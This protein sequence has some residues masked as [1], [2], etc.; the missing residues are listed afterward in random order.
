MGLIWN[1]RDETVDWV[2]ALSR[3]MAPYEDGTPR[4]HEGQWR[5]VFPAEGFGELR[6]ATFEHAH[7]GDFESVVVDR[8]LSVS[9]IAALPLSQRQEVDRRIRQLTNV[10]PDLSDQTE[11][12][13]P[14]RTLV[15]WA[16]KS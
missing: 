14:Y 15:A 12:K 3:I 9:F 13:F 6:E 16:K 7:R 10:Y 8:I 1:I 11:V 2:A 5:S 4:F